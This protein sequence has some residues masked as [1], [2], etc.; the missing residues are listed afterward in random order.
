MHLVKS[1]ELAVKGLHDYDCQIQ[2]SFGVRA[3]MNKPLWTLLRD[4]K[5]AHFDNVDI[6]EGV[7]STLNTWVKHYDIDSVDVSVPSVAEA[8]V[9]IDSIVGSMVDME[10][11]NNRAE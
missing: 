3:P 7:V 2:Q 5:L 8:K 10:E 1:W 4:I 6:H 11:A 9:V